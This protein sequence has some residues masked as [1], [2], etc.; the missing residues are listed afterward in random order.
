MPFTVSTVIVASNSLSVISKEGSTKLDIFNQSISK[1]QL[2]HHFN[3]GR[4]KKDTD[5]YSGLKF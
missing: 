4:I 3:F 5:K 2:F 1:I